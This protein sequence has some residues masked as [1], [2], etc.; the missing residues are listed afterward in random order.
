MS[1]N[2]EPI[3]DIEIVRTIFSGKWRF[4]VLR[5]IC[6]RPMRLSDLHRRIPHASKKM[7]IDTLRRMSESGWIKRTDRSTSV[8]R[9]EY[10]LAEDWESRLRAVIEELGEAAPPRTIDNPSNAAD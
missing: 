8:K 4:D 2:H 9:V 6:Q 5:A 1:E 3:S 7:L 10:E